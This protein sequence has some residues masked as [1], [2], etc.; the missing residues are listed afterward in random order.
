MRKACLGL[1]LVAGAFVVPTAHAALCTSDPVPAASLLLPWFEVGACAVP[2]SENTVFTVVNNAAA[3]RVVH[4]TLWTN[5]AVAALDF[6]LYLN[7]F[8][9]QD[10]DLRALFCDGTLPRTGRG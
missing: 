4:V 3:P 10:V 8:A 2:E 5:A 1:A 7:G 6:D 9:Q